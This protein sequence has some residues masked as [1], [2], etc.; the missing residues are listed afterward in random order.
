[1]TMSVAR[2]GPPAATTRH[3]PRARD[4]G[5]PA[6]SGGMKGRSLVEVL[7][8][9]V[10]LVVAAVFLAYAILHSGRG[11]ANGDGILLRARFDRIDGI[12]NGADV[13]IAGVKV[14][15]VTSSR[16]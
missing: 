11:S 9:A 4:A 1:M 16:I 15:S 13:R 2:A 3:G 12:T 10:I 5:R 8:G 14:G 6:G 7:T